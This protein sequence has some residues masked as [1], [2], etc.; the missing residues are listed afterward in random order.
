LAVRRTAQFFLNSFQVGGE[1]CGSAQ[2]YCAHDVM[3][4]FSPHCCICC[5]QIQR[6]VS[7]CCVLHPQSLRILP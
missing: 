2:P 4:Q 3:R 1:A 7:P 5:R 6:T